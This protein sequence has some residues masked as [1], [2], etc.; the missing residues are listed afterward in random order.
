MGGLGRSRSGGLQRP[1]N[2]NQKKGDGFPWQCLGCGEFLTIPHHH[3]PECG[4]HEVSAR[5][6]PTRCRSCGKT[7]SDDFKTIYNP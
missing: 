3:C 1:Q 6:G 7:L 2:R 5:R 4:L